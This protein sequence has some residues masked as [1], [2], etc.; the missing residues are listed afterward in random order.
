M[1]TTTWTRPWLTVA[2]SL[3][4]LFPLWWVCGQPFLPA[5]LRVLQPGLA[6]ACWW[7]LFLAALYLLPSS[8]H[9]EHAWRWLQRP[10]DGPGIWL[11]LVAATIFTGLQVANFTGGYLRSDDFVILTL[12][13]ER[14]WLDA[15]FTPYKEHTQPLLHLLF[16]LLWD[17]QNGSTLWLNLA[18]SVQF[19]ALFLALYAYTAAAQLPRLTYL[20][21]AI[22]LLSWARWGELTAGFYSQWFVVH[23]ALFSFLAF[24]S[25]LVAFRTGSRWSLVGL[26]LSLLLAGLS[27]LSAS[28]TFAL[29]GS[30][31]MLLVV[32]GGQPAAS[33]LRR[34]ALPFCL[35]A[36]LGLVFVLY[37]LAV[38][39]LFYQIEESQID[40]ANP[41]ASLL[42]SFVLLGSALGDF[43]L[44]YASVFQH[45]H[46][47]AQGGGVCLFFLLFIITWWR[48]PEAPL[49]QPA[50]RLKFHLLF[51]L[52][53]AWLY[54]L[55]VSL[56]RPDLSLHASSRYS[57]APFL[58]LSLLAGIC[59]SVLVTSRLIPTRRLSSVGF[60]LL[61]ALP[62]PAIVLGARPG[63][64]SGGPIR[65]ETLAIAQEN[66]RLIDELRR[67][68]RT[69]QKTT[70]P[71]PFS[72]PSLDA[73]SSKA[74]FDWLLIPGHDL[75]YLLP[76]LALGPQE[77]RL[78][79][80]PNTQVPRVSSA[81]N[82]ALSTSPYWQNL[83][84]QPVEVR[85]DAQ[86]YL[87][88]DDAPKRDLTVLSRAA[89]NELVVFS[90]SRPRN[91]VRYLTVQF[92][93]AGAPKADLHLL[94]DTP[95]LHDLYL[96]VIPAR[97]L[98]G[99]RS[100][101]VDLFQFHGVAQSP[102]LRHLRLRWGKEK[103]ATPQA[104]VSPTA[105]PL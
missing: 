56:G 79:P 39:H 27:N 1:T 63:W 15:I 71:A 47:L 5:G 89:G 11:A 73:R 32:M 57:L 94:V 103:M 10:C 26:A 69:L 7:A 105:L 99:Q 104:N 72:L 85:P 100:Q 54:C 77:L 8:L 62:L 64:Y 75:N 87:K 86:V 12:Q 31:L 70:A 29:T 53:A 84:L 88:K 55:M 42:G 80:P 41:L 18:A 65:S 44:P 30:S 58:C 37:Q 95:W 6:E 76:A 14:T 48:A 46:L 21:T 49:P 33:N 67:E 43:I 4:L 45:G 97:Q 9:R 2:L 61:L 66:Q 50:I 22:L 35:V 34:V 68:I 24:A 3:A 92:P 90:E 83:Y 96:G 17:P 16:L 93:K 52:A 13:Q 28:W 60:L 74:V 81:F 59:L 25:C 40:G 78:L 19:A 102:S 51:L 38:T 91:E 82:R 101:T 23:V 20:L 98:Q 36:G